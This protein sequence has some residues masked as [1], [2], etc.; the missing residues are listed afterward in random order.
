MIRTGNEEG[1]IPNEEHLL[2][3]S[4]VTTNKSGKNEDKRQRKSED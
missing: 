2:T 3:P 4:R 1:A